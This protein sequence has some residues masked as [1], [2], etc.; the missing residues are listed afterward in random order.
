MKNLSLVAKFQ[1]E[2]G[3]PGSQTSNEKCQFGKETHYG[4]SNFNSNL[5][6]SDRCLWL[7]LKCSLVHS[8]LWGPKG[9]PIYKHQREGIHHIR[10]H[11][12]GRTRM[13]HF[14]ISQ[15]LCQMKCVPAWPNVLMING[16]PS[17][18]AQVHPS[19]CPSKLCWSLLH[20]GSFPSVILLFSGQIPSWVFIR[21]YILT[22]S[23]MSM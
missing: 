2:R 9:P 13:L 1:K 16:F 3:G 7:C 5:S 17:R 21:Q 23:F 18:S 12:A 10:S 11:P 6:C 4:Q 20:S 8:V 15:I 19:K 14:G 22:T